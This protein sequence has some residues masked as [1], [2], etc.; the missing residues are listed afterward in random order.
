MEFIF[1][2]RKLKTSITNKM[3]EVVVNAG[4][5]RAMGWSNWQKSNMSGET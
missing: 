1:Q 4:T 3:I 5:R 2:W